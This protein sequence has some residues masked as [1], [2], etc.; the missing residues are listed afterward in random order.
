MPAMF[1]QQLLIF[2][3]SF[4][5]T[6]CGMLIFS[7]QISMPLG[8]MCIGLLIPALLVY[9]LHALNPEIKAPK[10]ALTPFNFFSYMGMYAAVLIGPLC[11]ALLMLN[12]LWALR[13]LAGVD[14][15]VSNIYGVDAGNITF[16][17]DCF[18]AHP[19]VE[20]AP[21][22]SVLA[23]FLGNSWP[24]YVHAPGAILCLVIGPCQLNGWIRSLYGHKI[25]KILGYT[26]VL[27]TVMATVGAVG[28]MIQTTSGIIASTGFMALAVLWNFTLAKGV[29][30]AR[31]GNIELHREWMIRN[32]FYTFSAI[33]FRFLPGIFLALGVPPEGNAAYSVGTWL[34][35]MITALAS[36]KFL[37]LTRKSK[38]QK[39]PRGP[40]IFQ[41]GGVN[42]S[43]QEMIETDTPNSSAI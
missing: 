2:L 22:C 12:V 37:E 32:Y 10:Y 26:Y 8:L 14:F 34:T 39:N 35:V 20:G 29:S 23:S 42:T 5:G 18:A 3:I 21:T 24:L 15:V 27:C 31:A 43:I 28:L 17:R 30:Y 19:I 36:E 16:L 7:V 33:P 6:T 13:W 41:D 38:E 1:N 9:P 25:H 11:Y 40:S 4:V